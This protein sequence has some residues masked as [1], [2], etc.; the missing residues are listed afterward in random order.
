MRAITLI[1][2]S[3]PASQ[4][5]PTAVAVR[6]WGFRELLVFHRP[7]H[8]KLL[9]RIRMKRRHVDY[10][11]ECASSCCERGFQIGEGQANLSLEI[12]FGRTIGAAADLTRHE[13]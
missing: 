12:G 6:I 7:V 1:S 2:K 11:V 13:Q 8:A 4:L 5:T 10:V 3:K 9:F